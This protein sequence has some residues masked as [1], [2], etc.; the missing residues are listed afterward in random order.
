VRLRLQGRD[1][2]TVRQ[3]YA[4]PDVAAHYG[5]KN[6]LYSGWQLHVD[7]P[8]LRPGRYELEVEGTDQE[9]T[10]GKLEPLP[11]QVTE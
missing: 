1:I 7:L 6:L 2:G 11:V 9:G 3:F 4:R 8:A 10:S 5:R